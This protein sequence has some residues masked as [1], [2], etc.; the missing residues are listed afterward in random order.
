MAV[1]WLF[2]LMFNVPVSRLQLIMLAL[3]RRSV[4]AMDNIMQCGAGKK[5]VVGAVG[6]SHTSV[7][8]VST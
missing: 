7:P 1:T 2:I 8:S 3:S 6:V 4:K 5:L